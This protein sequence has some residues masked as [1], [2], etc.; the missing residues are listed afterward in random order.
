MAKATRNSKPDAGSGAE[1]APRAGAAT[2]KDVAEFACVSK[3]TVSRFVNNPGIVS[4]A[5]RER[6]EVAIKHLGWVPHAAARALATQRTGTIGA[7]VPTLSN[8]HFATAIQTLQDEL[9]GEGYTLLLACSEYE[10]EREYRQVRKMLERGVDAVVVVGEGHHAE[11]YPLLEQR[12]IPCVSTFTYPPRHGTV[13]V[14]VDNYRAFHDCT[15]YLLD[16]GHR[17]IGMIAQNADTND[18]AAARRM[19]VRDALAERGI[20]IHPAHE[21]EGYWS[22]KEGR[23]LLRRIME[24][25]VPP[26]T[27]IVCGNGSFAMGAML[28]AIAIGIDVP[29]QLSLIGFDDFELMAELPIPITTV[30]VP[31]A[32]I[33]KQAARLILAQ[34]DGQA[35]VASIGWSAELMVRASCAPP[36]KDD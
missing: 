9:E 24:A 13:C 5:V 34:L 6:I 29:S 30:R 12:R 26:P 22:V 20:A 35:E 25:K 17:R 18:R 19:G 7:V 36:R 11:L 3:A 10:L 1:P 27:A 23:Q 21:V 32:E 14:G 2:L 28:E 8:E 31:S 15:N 16:L 4:P 33:G